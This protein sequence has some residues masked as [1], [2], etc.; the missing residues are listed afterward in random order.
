MVCLFLSKDEFG[1]TALHKAVLGGRNES[2]FILL[3]VNADPTLLNFNLA[4]P[5]QLA[6][7]MGLLP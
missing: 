6:A 4:T 2:V 7:K 3:E 5:I 1:D